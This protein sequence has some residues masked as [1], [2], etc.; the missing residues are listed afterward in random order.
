MT[1]SCDP[2]DQLHLAQQGWEGREDMARVVHP[3]CWGNLFS[4]CPWKVTCSLIP[5]EALP[6]KL[7]KDMLGGRRTVAHGIATDKRSGP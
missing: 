2:S 6:D 3:S 7:G 1:S 4:E 5:H